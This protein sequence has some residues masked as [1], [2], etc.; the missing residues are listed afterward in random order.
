MR[1]RSRALF[2]VLA[3]L[4][5]LAGCDDDGLLRPEVADDLFVSY[6][7]LG[8]SITAGF[9]SDGINAA[10]QAEAYPV[11]LAGQMGTPFRVPELTLPGCPPPLTNPLSGERVGNGER[12]DCR[13]RVVPPPS[14]IHNLAVP[15]AA[16]MDIL[17]NL[18]Q[19]SNPNPL[20]TLL[21][22]GR[23]QLE[24]ARDARPTFA[25][26][27]V[28][29]N[30]ILGAA[31]SGVV[32]EENVTPVP[33]FRAR[34][35][36]T[37]DEL[38]GMGSRGGILIG[39]PEVILIPHLSPGAAY[40][41]L[42]REGAFPEG[43]QVHPSCAPADAGGMGQETLVPFGYGIAILLAQAAAGVEVELNCAQDPPVLS[44]EEIQTLVGTV[45]GYNQAL[46]E[47]AAARGWAFHDP[48]PTFRE[49]A[50]QRAI[51]PFPNLEEPTELF[52]PVFSLDGI[53]PSGFA[54]ALLADELIQAIN[55]HYGT[56][57][58]PLEAG[59]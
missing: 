43:F 36:E 10:T 22:G 18:D 6:V 32:T 25:S 53:H 23:T 15:G 47:E 41:A 12:E 5:L 34:L 55:A 33:T 20:T 16:T 9:Q 37:L 50:L 49:L 21:L 58:S 26:V 1:P 2:P 56:N 29:N 52:G 38:E 48:N 31:I 54:H 30:D 3:A 51:P 44:P 46:S 24:A 42:H 19:A 35:A 27:W 4:L 59:P 14:V 7:S 39:V 17:S 45:A 57:L 11:L 13:L 8:N 40:W 28:G